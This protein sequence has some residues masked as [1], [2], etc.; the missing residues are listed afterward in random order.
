VTPSS[1]RCP[2][3]GRGTYGY[4]CQRRTCCGFGKIWAGDQRRKLFSNLEA[5]AESVPSGIN[6]VIEFFTVTAPGQDVLPWDHRFCKHDP[7]RKCSGRIGCLVNPDFAA[8][9]NVAAPG[10]WSK[11]HRAAIMAVLRDG[12]RSPVLAYVWQLHQRG[13]W[14]LHLCLAF[15]TPRERAAARLYMQHVNRLAAS[16]G[17]GHVDMHEDVKRADQAA[18]YL[19]SYLITGRAGKL[20]LQE[21]VTRSDA[22]SL[23]VYVARKLTSETRVTMRWLRERRRAF[24]ELRSWARAGLSWSEWPRFAFL[25]EWWKLDAGKILVSAGWSRAP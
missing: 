20:T 8:A 21:S 23:M 11:C 22:P 3:C 7:G 25:V 12:G 13:V 5:Y 14:H 18:A 9:W 1:D 10:H 15:S 19:S 24:Q 4:T 17:F 16:Y 2:H 6:P